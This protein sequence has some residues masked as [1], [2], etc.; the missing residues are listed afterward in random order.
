MIKIRKL[1]LYAI[2]VFITLS[3]LFAGF[4]KRFSWIPAG[5]ET[6]TFIADYEYQALDFLS[7]NNALSGARIVSDPLTMRIFTSLDNREWIIEHSMNPIFFTQAGQCV[8]TDIRN[9]ILLSSDS[10]TAYDHLMN[11]TSTVPYDEKGY[12][13]LKDGIP[14][15]NL[16]LI[17]SGRTAY[18]LDKSEGISMPSVFF[19]FSY[20]VDT[21]HIF[22]FLDTKFFDLIYKVDQQIYIFAVKPEPDYNAT[23]YFKTMAIDLELSKLG[24]GGYD[25]NLSTLLGDNQTVRVDV[26]NGTYEK[27]ALVHKFPQPEDLSGF[28][29]LSVRF[30]GQNTNATFRISIDGPTI[31]DRTIFLFKDTNA[32]YRTLLF[33]LKTPYAREGQANLN[34]TIQILLTPHTR[35]DVYT[36]TWYILIELF[37][38]EYS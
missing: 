25:A 18:W 29:M 3:F 24:H 38:F 6:Q 10:E 17:F 20:K 7:K 35:D 23:P 8:V 27:W 2:F 32:E 1:A 33:D 34:S 26:K 12:L 16:I 14:N 4:Q 11:L 15:P 28:A 36:G 5:S 13:N 31:L 19:P 37:K 22:Q 9:N 30:K 21:K